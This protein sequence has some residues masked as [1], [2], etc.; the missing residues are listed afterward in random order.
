MRPRP[1]DGAPPLLLAGLAAFV[2]VLAW[3][4]ALSLR[5][6]E[7]PVFAPT[8]PGR[9]RAGTWA[10]DT[11]TLDASGEVAWR[12]ASLTSGRVLAV[13]DTAGWEL[14]ARRYRL[15]VAGELADL[16]AVAWDSARAIAATRWVRS[17]PSEDGNPADRWYRYGFV[18]HLLEPNGHVL[19]LRTRDGRRYKL[20]VLGYYCPGVRAGCLT[21]RYAPLPGPDG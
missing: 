18:T 7:A 11:L 21:I 16:G 15:T 9:V 5:R 8:A 19:A 10:T 3:L 17:R 2:L 6:R 1:F 14:A 4:V 20:Q 13:P 12:Y